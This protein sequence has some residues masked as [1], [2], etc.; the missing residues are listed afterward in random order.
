MKL[1]IFDLAFYYIE[2]FCTE[3]PDD[4]TKRKIIKD[5]GV[6]LTNGWTVGD[7]TKHIRKFKEKN[8][9]LV[10]DIPLLFSKLSKSEENLLVP[11]QYYYHNQ[12]RITPGPPKRI[13][14]YNTGEIKSM[15][16]EYFLEIRAS[17]T[18]DDL[19]D[20]F[21]EQF[22]MPDRW[23]ERRRI[24]GSFKYLLKTHDIDLILFMIDAASNYSY[25][26]DM[27]MAS[28]NPIKLGD[29][30]TIAQNHLNEKITENNYSGDDRIVPRKRV[31]S[32]RSG[33]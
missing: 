6:L 26:E 20:Y 22:N 30:K 28:F 21:L 1:S 10:P 7:V 4:D 23:E 18:V 11:N 19:T 8:P 33:D 3:E 9:G 5:F 16:E 32:F 14:D 27:D 24:I 12:L 25:S 29:W 2:R 17:Y 13:L 31:L 15:D